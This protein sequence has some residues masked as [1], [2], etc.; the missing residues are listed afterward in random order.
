MY[1]HR[2][3]TQMRETIYV[4]SRVAILLQRLGTGNTLCTVY[5]VAELYGVAESKIS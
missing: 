2:K 3:N 5:G 4:E 1:L